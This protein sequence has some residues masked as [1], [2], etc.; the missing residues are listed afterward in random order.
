MGGVS[1]ECILKS[2]L[3][4]ALACLNLSRVLVTSVELL[5]TQTKK[6][7]YPGSSFYTFAI[8]LV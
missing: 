3:S 6:A 8:F 5:V 4:N 2:K 7:V 1:I